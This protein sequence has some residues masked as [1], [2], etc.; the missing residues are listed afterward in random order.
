MEGIADS[1]FL[2]LNAELGKIIAP[3]RH[4]L[5]RHC[6]RKILVKDGDSASPSI[7]LSG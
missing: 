5:T 1:L 7:N 4:P 2:R 3:L 6:L